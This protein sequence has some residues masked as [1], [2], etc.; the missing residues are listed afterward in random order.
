VASGRSLEQIAAERAQ[1]WESK[2][3]VKEN[4]RAGAIAAGSRKRAGKAIDGAKDKPKASARRTMPQ[5]A[6]VAKLPA[7]VAPMLTTLVSTAPAGD[8]WIHEIKYDGYR[9]VCRIDS[10][11]A[12]LYSRNG[13]DWTPS[14]RSVADD[15]PKLPLLSA[16][17][18]GEVVVLDAAGRPSF[19]ALQNALSAGFA[20][21]LFFAFDLIYVDG[22]DLRRVVLRSASAC[23]ARSS[24]TALASSASGP[25]SVA[26]VT[27]SS[28]RR[29]R[30]ASRVRCA[31]EPIR[32]ITTAR[33]HATGSR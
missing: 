20:A 7:M 3:S 15:L 27:N 10:G 32:S 1:V 16:F 21:L 12:H 18:D 13:K 4:V 14:F 22:H 8:E 5:G 30:S 28:A 6:K 11:K 33:E 24:A 31:S 25:R 19:Q 17:I 26:T 9:M 23:C 29:A 2:L